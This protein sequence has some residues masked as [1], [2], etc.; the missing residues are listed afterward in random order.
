MVKNKLLQSIIRVMRNKYKIIFSHLLLLMMLISSFQGAW[1][2]D[3]SQSMHEEENSVVQ[4]LLSEAADM[5]VGNDHLMDHGK[6]NASHTNCNTQ[7]Y[8]SYPYAPNVSI[9]TARS[10]SL[11][12]ISTDSSAFPSRFPDLLIRPPKI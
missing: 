4:L 6:K 11:Q 9:L 7:C 8:V 5:G 2:I 3:F 1:A 12:K 10:K